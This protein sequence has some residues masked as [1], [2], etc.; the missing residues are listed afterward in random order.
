M[1]KSKIEWTET[2][3][4]IVT[5]CTPISPGCENCYGESMAKR[6]WGSRKF[7]DIR[8]HFDRLDQPLKWKKPSRIFVCSMGDLFHELVSFSEIDSVF[9]TIIECQ[10]TGKE[11]T[12]I[13]LTKRPKRMKAYLE[14][15]GHWTLPNIWCGVTAENQEMAD[16][17]IPTLLQIPASVLFVSVEPML[18]YVDLSPW[19]HNGLDW[20]IVGSESGL[21][22]RPAENRW[23]ISILDQ[24]TTFK[25]PIF[26]KQIEIN[27][28]LVKMPEINGKVWA[29]YPE[30]Y[31]HPA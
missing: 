18:S 23:I 29:E 22:R 30:A 8:F 15:T 26:I 5:G 3:W 2:V 4:N 7:S 19:L 11:H 24:C 1:N 21:K 9:S 10:D 12:F 16:K 14:D 13:L 25:T 20:I 27:G 17:R 28:K 31:A 6:F